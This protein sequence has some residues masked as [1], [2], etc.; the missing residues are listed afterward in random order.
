MGF[1]RSEGRVAHLGA[2]ADE[3]VAGQ[4]LQLYR[5]SKTHRTLTWIPEKMG[6]INSEIE[7]AFRGA[8]YMSEAVKQA[9]ME[10]VKDGISSF[11]ITDDLMRAKLGEIAKSPAKVEAIMEKVNDFLFDYTALD[12]FERNVVRRFIMPFYS[13]YKNIFKL[14]VWTLP[15][16]YPGRTT[17]L[18]GLAT[19]GKEQLD[20]SYQ[21]MGVDPATL[22]EWMKGNIP[23]ERQEDGSILFWNPRGANPFETLTSNALSI[24]S[25]PIKLALERA[26]GQDT[27]TGR[28][29]TSPEV[30]EEGGRQLRYDPETGRFEETEVAPPL[31]SHLLRQFPQYDLVR[32]FFVPY[33]EYDTGTLLNPQVRP[34]SKRV[35]LQRKLVGYA[36]FPQGQ[37]TPPEPGKGD[38]QE[39]RRVSLLYKQLRAQDRSGQ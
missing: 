21:A 6:Q 7:T 5:E 9:R 32:K 18:R 33:G 22:P 11:H 10:I 4:A 15:M 25:P 37:W 19:M 27:F 30:I 2:A 38:R 1:M 34:G 17:L 26:L 12:G 23:M 13:W 31:I 14:A 36:G 16:K 35:N 24:L 3:S 8:N 29:F 28:K 20:D 39:R